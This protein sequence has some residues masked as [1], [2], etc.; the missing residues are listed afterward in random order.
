[1]LI[2]N[3]ILFVQ[4]GEIAFRQSELNLEGLLGQGKG[5][6]VIFVSINTRSNSNVVSANDGVGVVKF[7]VVLNDSNAGLNLN[8]I[9]KI[10]LIVPFEILNKI[11]RILLRG[12]IFIVLLLI[13]LASDSS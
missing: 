2:L 7:A 4:L 6:N 5:L 13:G 1:L 9:I 8:A 11:E 3:D 10:V 12:L